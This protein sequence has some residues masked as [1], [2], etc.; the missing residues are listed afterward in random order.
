M[1]VAADLDYQTEMSLSGFSAVKLFFPSRSV[2]SSSQ[3]SHYAQ[4]HLRSEDLCSLSLRAEYLYK[5][6]GILLLEQFILSP[7][8]PIY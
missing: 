5:L 4:P 6:F 8:P 1:T 2:L 3:G 7:L